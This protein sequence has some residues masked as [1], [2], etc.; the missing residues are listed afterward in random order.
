MQRVEHR[1][2]KVET[3]NRNSWCQEDSNPFGAGGMSGVLLLVMG[4][5][6]WKLRS[7]AARGVGERPLP[8][9]LL[10]TEGAGQKECGLP[11]ASWPPR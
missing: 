2:G 7:R 6:W 3:P 4:A 8:E 9:M 1:D 10:K 5:T 11:S